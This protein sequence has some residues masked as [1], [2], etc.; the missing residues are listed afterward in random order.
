MDEAVANGKSIRFNVTEYDYNRPFE[1]LR[2]GST[3][4]EVYHM[5]FNPTFFNRSNSFFYE[6]GWMRN[7]EGLWV[8]SGK[9]DLVG[10]PWYNAHY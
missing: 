6:E 5:Q 10:P 2:F 8:R 1:T 4:R 9:F 3:D 7:A